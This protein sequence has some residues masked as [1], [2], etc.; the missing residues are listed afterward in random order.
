M[1]IPDKES[2][3]NLAVAF[4]KTTATKSRF[5]RTVR[6]CVETDAVWVFDFFHPRWHELKRKGE[7]YGTRVVVDKHS[8]KAGH[9]AALHD[10]G[11]V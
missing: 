10:K 1:A 11:V 9:Y 5:S 7:P 3:K 6:R 2:A 4:L 8:G